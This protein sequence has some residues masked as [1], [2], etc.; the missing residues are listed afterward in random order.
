MELLSWLCL[1]HYHRTYPPHDEQK[2]GSKHVEVYYWNKLIINSPSGWFI[3][4]GYMLQFMVRDKKIYESHVQSN[5]MSKRYAWNPTM[6]SSQNVGLWL[7]SQMS[8]RSLYYVGF[9][10][11]RWL[12]SIFPS[13]T[14]RHV[15]VLIYTDV[16][17]DF[18]PPSSGKKC[19]SYRTNWSMIQGKKD[20]VRSKRKQMAS[21]VSIKQTIFGDTNHTRMIR[22]TKYCLL[23]W[24]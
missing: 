2:D 24:N 21:T 3:L 11:R 15:V 4:Y 5:V 7:K 19:N 23:L 16:S 13:G 8:Q 9:I 17:K 18:L 10:L 1:L 6:N 20:K 12:W 22:V 14:W